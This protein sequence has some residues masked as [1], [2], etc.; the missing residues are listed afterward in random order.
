MSQTQGDIVS[1]LLGLL[2]EAV[3]HLSRLGVLWN[4]ANK[5]KAH[6]WEE[7]KAAAPKLSIAFDSYEVRAPAEFDS[8]FAAIR[9][10]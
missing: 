7:T 6:D 8:V 10:K 1:K 3:P 5:S 4:S 2:R 9:Q